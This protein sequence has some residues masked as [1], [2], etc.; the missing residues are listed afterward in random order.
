MPDNWQSYPVPGALL[1]VIG[2][3]LVIAGLQ[4]RAPLSIVGQVL[5]S[6][7]AVAIGLISYSL[8]LWHWPVFVL[9]RWTV[10][11]STPAQKLLALAIAVALS[12]ISYFLVERPLRASPWLRVPARAIA[13][14]LLAVVLC[15]GAADRMFRNSVAALGEHGDGEPR[16]LV[17]GLRGEG[18]GRQGLPGRMAREAAG[19]RRAPS[20]R[21]GL[22]AN[23]PDANARLFVIGDSHAT[24]YLHLLADYARLTR[25]PVA[26]H[27]TP[28]CYFVHL[29]PSAPGCTAIVRMPCSTKSERGLKAG[30]VIFM[31]S[32][33]V[34]R[35]RDQWG[36]A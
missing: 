17:F 31:P 1:P 16:R 4:G 18:E 27:Q 2:A 30:D 20:C 24:A 19:D 11:F 10:G 25:V 6:R 22:T 15:A 36:D 33:R 34:P 29:V 14:Y 28:G 5:S 13:V 26:L 23:L 35:F 32:L 21:S 3:L 9:F 12:L 8:Y 7:V